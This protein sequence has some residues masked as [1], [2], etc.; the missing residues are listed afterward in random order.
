MLYGKMYLHSSE[1]FFSPVS[2][3]ILSLL[4]ITLSEMQVTAALLR[5][6]THTSSIQ[7]GFQALVCMQMMF[8]V[9]TSRLGLWFVRSDSTVSI[10]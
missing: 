10:L 6:E 7:V 9:G 1:A 4:Y 5:K 3:R 8:C 2:N